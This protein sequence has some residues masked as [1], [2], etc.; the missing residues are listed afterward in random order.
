[1][2]GRTRSAETEEGLGA[3]QSARR[4]GQPSA[5]FAELGRDTIGELVVGP[6]PHFPLVDRSDGLSRAPD[7]NCLEVKV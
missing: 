4:A 6:G 1:M 7:P 5:E 3:T 2:A